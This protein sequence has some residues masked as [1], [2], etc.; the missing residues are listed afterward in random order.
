MTADSISS[1]L[2][3]DSVRLDGA[4][5]IG[6]TICPGKH[7]VSAFSGRWAR[8]LETDVRAIVDWGAAAVVTLME[9]D[10]LARLKVSAIGETVER[11]KMDWHFLPIVDV[12]VPDEHF[13]NLWIYS[14]HS[15]RRVLVDGRKL[16]IHCK[17]G[18]GRTGTIAARL[19][20]ELGQNP[21]DAIRLVRKARPGAIETSAQERHVRGIS[22]LRYDV[23]QVDRILGC[24]LGGA[25]GDAFGYAVEFEHWPQI[26]TRFGA[27]GITR[28][29]E[30]DGKIL[31]SDDTQMTLFS[32]EALARSREPIRRYDL[33]AV[34]EEIRLSYLD[35]LQTQGEGARSWKI[36]GTIAADARLRHRR[37]PGNTCLDALRAGGRG[38]PEKKHN[39]SNGC[40]GVMRVA[41]IGLVTELDPKQ[42]AELAAR[43]AALTHGHPSGYLSAAALAAIVRLLLVGRG[44]PDA[45]QTACEIVSEWKDADETVKQIDAAPDWRAARTETIA[46]QSDRLERDGLAR[47]LWQSDSSAP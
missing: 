27:K 42:A 8:D 39:D 12:D 21:A 35:W 2:R 10:E 19:M 20:V 7:E 31:V 46:K 28:P 24:L 25:V 13:E 22:K 15:L 38:S 4:S 37:A 34:L 26:K 6:M 23:E 5:E 17:G 3:I 9:K 33:K 11:A 44:L 30:H 32:L 40:G 14:G 1:P 18:L 43:A 41:P 16:L 47:K 29:V 45:A 36:V